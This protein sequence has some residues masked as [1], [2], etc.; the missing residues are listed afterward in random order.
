MVNR[1]RE[2]RLSEKQKHVWCGLPEGR[3]ANLGQV[4]PVA[5]GAQVPV[6]FGPVEFVAERLQQQQQIP[7]SLRGL[8]IKERST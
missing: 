5:F 6:E 3:V 7:N 4:S 1:E 2:R 8:G